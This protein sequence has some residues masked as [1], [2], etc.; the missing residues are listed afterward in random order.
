MRL[1]STSMAFDPEPYVEVLAKRLRKARA[2][3]R[4][5]PERPMSGGR[6]RWALAVVTEANSYLHHRSIPVHVIPPKPCR[7]QYIPDHRCLR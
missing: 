4:D 1:D 6:I 7:R 2:I 5:P 3:L